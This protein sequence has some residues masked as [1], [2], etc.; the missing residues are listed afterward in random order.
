MSLYK[1]FNDVQH[2]YKGIT[3][4]P[5]SNPDQSWEFIKQYFKLGGKTEVFN[6]N[7]ASELKKGGKHI[8]T[9]S[10]Y[11]IGCLLRK[12]V[13]T[14]LA[15]VMN[16]FLPERK[17][18]I[19]YKFEYTWFLTCLYHDTAHVIEETKH[20][21]NNVV[22]P[23][24]HFKE[25]IEKNKIKH[26][27]Y[28]HK[29]PELALQVPIYKEELV[30][31]YYYYCLTYRKK[32]EHGIVGGFLLFDKLKKNYNKKWIQFKKQKEL[33]DDEQKGHFEIDGLTWRKQHL[34]HFAYISHSIIEHN[35]W[36]DKD[37]ELYKKFGLQDLVETN[38]RI[39]NKGNPL[40][41]F[42]AIVDTIEP[43]K[44]FNNLPPLWVWNNIDM[45]YDTENNC[46]EISVLHDILNLKEWISKINSL[47]SWLSVNVVSSSDNRNVIINILEE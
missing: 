36:Y 11:Y 12:M 6:L 21:G 17:S 43:T 29:C 28:N 3:V 30:Q 1:K 18:D 39:T 44:F 13:E 19:Q 4:D 38:N 10:M 47:E 23:S 34:D 32:I 16:T 5:I 8:H 15:N 33:L 42:L 7:F 24:F 37:E 35:I 41:F 27:V 46:I 9:V 22:N 25:M 45:Y 14:K 26:N 20:V 31:N 2:Y 40:L